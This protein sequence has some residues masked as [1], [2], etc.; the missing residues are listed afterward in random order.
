L[1]KGHLCHKK[2]TFDL[3][4]VLSAQLLVLRRVHYYQL[5]N[6]MDLIYHIFFLF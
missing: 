6:H 3:F 2:N 5:R 4:G 1:K